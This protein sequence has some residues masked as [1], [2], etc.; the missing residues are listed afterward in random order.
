MPLRAI[1]NPF[2]AARSPLRSMRRTLREVRRNSRRVERNLFDRIQGAGFV[3]AAV[4]APFLVMAMQANVA[5]E[6]RAALLVV[7]VFADARTDGLAAFP[8]DDEKRG[9]VPAGTVPLADV[10]L[11]ERVERRGWPLVTAH[12][13]FATELVVHRTASCPERRT[14]EVLRAAEPVVA[15]SGL[16]R[17]ADVEHRHLAAKVFSFTIWWVLGSLAIA[18]ALVPFRIGARLWR[19]GRT[20]VR[21][22]RIDR[23][24]CPNCGYDARESI[25]RG[26]CPECGSELYERPDY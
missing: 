8:V 14:G 1:L 2:R 6:T 16:A 15:R 25:L 18:A 17:A 20:S 12:R 9:A 22:G 26:R 10:E 5:R 21:Q 11:V 19:R 13:D 7:R 4:A 3:V 24:R 23:C